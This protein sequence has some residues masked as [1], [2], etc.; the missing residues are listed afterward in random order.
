MQYN[1]YII[2]NSINCGR[3]AKN[4]ITYSTSYQNCLF[5][6]SLYYVRASKKVSKFRNILIRLYTSIV[7]CVEIHFA[8]S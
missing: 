7:Y 4:I 1:F 5:R 2:V 8:H 6:Q 3:D